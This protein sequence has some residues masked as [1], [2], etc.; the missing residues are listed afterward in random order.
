ME[1]L[2]GGQFFAA[3]LLVFGVLG[4]LWFVAKRGLLMK[5]QQLTQ[6]LKLEETLYL[7]NRHKLVRVKDGERRYVL[8]ISP[9]GTQTVATY[10][11][12]EGIDA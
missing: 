2:A 9:T 11:Q 4:G 8:L 6:H 7:D 3:C 1:F 10:E 5:V 12:A